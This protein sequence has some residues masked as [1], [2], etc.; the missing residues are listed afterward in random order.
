VIRYSLT[1]FYI[2]RTTIST[3]SH[4]HLGEYAELRVNTE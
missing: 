3:T 4:N 2:K 1:G